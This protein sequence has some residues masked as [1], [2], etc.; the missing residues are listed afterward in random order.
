MKRINDSF[1][2][3]D[4]SL[5]AVLSLHY[6]LEEIDRKNPK[7]ALFIF[8]NNKQMEKLIDSYWRGELKVNPQA[9]FQQLKFIK[10][11][12]YENS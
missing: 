11:R 6:P 12:L 9:Y 1:K 4:L 5:A 8:K 2:S 7:K 10:T 3:S